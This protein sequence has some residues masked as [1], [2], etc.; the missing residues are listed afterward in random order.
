MNINPTATQPNFTAK[1]KNNDF[2]KNYVKDAGFFEKRALKSS[3]EKLSKVYPEDVL[4][5]TEDKKNSKYV[6]KN[7]NKKTE[8]RFDSSLDVTVP[9]MDVDQKISYAVKLSSLIKDIA[10]PGD[11]CHEKVFG[12]NN[13][14]SEA[15]ADKEIFDMLA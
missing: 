15:N 2:M 10:K 13:K 4:E 8:N 7:L 11:Y 12:I 9:M 3:L 14:Q 1:V 5:I 6:V